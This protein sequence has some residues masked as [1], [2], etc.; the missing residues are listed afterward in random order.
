[1]SKIKSFFLDIVDNILTFLVGVIPVLIL[2][3]FLYFLNGVSSYEAIFANLDGMIFILVVLLG[4][5]IRKLSDL[6]S[7]NF[8]HSRPFV[9]KTAPTVSIILICVNMALF[10]LIIALRFYF[11]NRF[12]NQIIYISWCVII[13]TIIFTLSFSIFYKH[14]VHF[15]NK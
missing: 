13:P 2:F 4:N 15:V 10:M 9:A 5:I 6:K 11:D 12:I 8:K 3:V 7:P 1:M 14:Q